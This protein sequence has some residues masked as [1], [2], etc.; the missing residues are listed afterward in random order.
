MVN[1]LL[2]Y[3]GSLQY[4]A[5]SHIQDILKDLINYQNFEMYLHECTFQSKQMRNKQTLKIHLTRE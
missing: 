4:S 1:L 3:M 2:K 5:V